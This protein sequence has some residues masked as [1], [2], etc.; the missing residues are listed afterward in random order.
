MSEEIKEKNLASDKWEFE[1]EQN[2]VG[3]WNLLLKEDMRQN[4]D[5]YKNED[6]KIKDNKK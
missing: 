6:N 4:P 5:L 2:W 1:S 3:F